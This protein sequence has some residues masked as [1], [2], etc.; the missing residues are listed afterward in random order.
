MCISGRC[1]CRGT[2]N[3]AVIIIDFP[4]VIII[5]YILGIRVFNVASQIAFWL[6]GTRFRGGCSAAAA[7]AKS[8]GKIPHCQCGHDNWNCTGSVL[9]S[10]F[11]TILRWCTQIAWQRKI[12]SA[13]MPTPL[14]SQEFQ[15][16]N[17][18]MKTASYYSCHIGW[19][20]NLNEACHCNV[21]KMDHTRAL[22]SW[23][24]RW[25]PKTVRN[26]PTY[27]CGNKRVD[28]HSGGDGRS[29][30]SLQ[31]S[32]PKAFV[33]VNVAGLIPLEAFY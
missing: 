27:A 22:Q 14:C 12:W 15:A 3:S 20:P 13:A 32:R 23:H 11:K 18:L 19:V 2:I 16:T 9:K 1:S 17:I 5:C 30:S 10:H 33:T 29:F 8:T 21:E 6:I 26:F 31:S 25:F 24:D 4:Q 7:P 28:S